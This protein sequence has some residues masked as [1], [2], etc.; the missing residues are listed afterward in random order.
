[1][2]SVSK[3][4]PV[5]VL[6]MLVSLSAMADNTPAA[7]NSDSS[8]ELSIDEA[9]RRALEFSPRLE[10]FD[11]ETRARDGEVLQ[12]GLRPNPMVSI[13]IEEFR[14]SEGPVSRATASTI[15]LG[16]ESLDLPIPGNGGDPNSTTLN[17]PAITPGMTR[18]NEEGP[19]S[20]FREALF[21]L[22]VSQ[23]FE[24]GGKRAKRV[25]VAELDRDLARWDFE[26]ARASVI[27]ETAILFN[28]VIAAQAAHSYWTELSRIAIAA[29]DHVGI[30]VDG[31][32]AASIDLMR[33]ESVRDLV[34]LE[35]DQAARRLDAVRSALSLQWGAETPDFH[36]AM[37]VVEERPPLPSLLELRESAERNPDIARWQ[38]EIARREAIHRLERSKRIPD[39]TL[40][41]GLRA[42]PLRS[43]ASWEASWDGSSL[44]YTRGRVSS[45]RGTDWSIVIDAAIELPIFNR[46]QGSIRAAESRVS[47]AYAEQ[48]QAQMDVGSRI[49]GAHATASAAFAET[50]SLAGS[51]LPN[52]EKTYRLVKE[53][54][55]AG[56]YR[57][58]ELLDAEREVIELR[59]DLL[60]ATARYQAELIQLYFLSGLDL[61]APDGATPFEMEDTNHE[62]E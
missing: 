18:S 21:T 7:V 46:N 19:A 20:G 29:C 41:I 17:L 31:G 54:Y 51:I 50:E 22:R 13:E 33:A 12:A 45:D 40:G 57:I 30:E 27:A 11:W 8:V 42:Q 38:T 3:S 43:R 15:G 47:K 23:A 39:L 34:L 52:A 49:S 6:A 61:T 53:G 24:L 62:Q 25:R 26:A 59:L 60:D 9:L 10:A 56:R 55:D 16:T 35:V 37:G 32:R 36:R 58:F 14:L 44:D 5:Y 1:M 2:C 48:R 28:D 4:L